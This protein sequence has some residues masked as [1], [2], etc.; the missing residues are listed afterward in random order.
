MKGAVVRQWLVPL[1]LLFMGGK[2]GQESHE[3]HTF[4]CSCFPR[5]LYHSNE[6][7]DHCWHGMFQ[8]YA[9]HLVLALA[10]NLLLQDKLTHP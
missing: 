6:S 5:H 9:H 7:S 4:G 1:R 2:Q 3:P 8:G 10:I